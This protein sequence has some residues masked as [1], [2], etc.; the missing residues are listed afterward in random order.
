M[1]L[2]VIYQNIVIEVKANINDHQINDEKLPQFSGQIVSSA[3]F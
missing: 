1:L 2:T 3:S